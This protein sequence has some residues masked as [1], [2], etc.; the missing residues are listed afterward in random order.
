MKTDSRVTVLFYPTGIIHFQ[1]L[2]I[3][4]EKLPDYRFLVIIEPWV[5]KHPPEALVPTRKEDRFETKNGRLPDDV[6]EESVDLLFLFMAYPNYF[7]LQLIH[8][9]VKRNIPVVAIEEVNQLALNSGIINH[10]FLPLDFFG[11]SSEIEKRGF[12][13]LGLPEHRVDVTG[14]PF[15]DLSV[16]GSFSVRGIREEYGIPPG[17]KICLLVLGSLKENDMVSLETRKVRYQLLELVS[18]GLTEDYWLLVKPHPTESG[19][20]LHEIK[21]QYPEAV[22]V[23]PGYPIDPLLAQSDLVVSRGNSQIGLLSML[24]KIPLIIVPAGIKTIFHGHLDEIIARSPFDFRRIAKNYEE[25][26]QIDFDRILKIHLPLNRE[27][28][29]NRIEEFFLRA[30]N[31]NA[32]HSEQV[33]LRISILFAFL[34][35]T[36]SARNI[37]DGLAHHNSTVLLKKLYEK[38]IQPE[39]FAGL[40]EYFPA[41]I[42]R[43]HLQAL[44]IRT[45]LNEKDNARLKKSVRY[46]EGFEGEVNPHTF[47]D[48]LIGRIE[49]E[50]RAGREKTAERLYDKFCGDYSIFRYYRQAFGM[51]RFVYQRNSRHAVLRKKLWALS[52]LHKSFVRKQIKEK[53]CSSTG[54]K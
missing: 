6:W 5:Q 41:K 40:L 30:L 35:Y 11:V 53:F 37:A 8:E 47:M 44:L 34:G 51:L 43:W 14:W 29:L 27:Q 2:R 38:I 10:Y 36:A 32:L 48:D 26:R 24:Y 54:R 7:R 17:K 50:Y 19:S 4:K 18:G 42:D 31:E 33:L 25:R 13:E 20:S 39:E 12:L 3:L 9:A 52:N 46:L 22:L 16:P 49:L 45:L 15:Y 21:K 28:S 1:N 23:A